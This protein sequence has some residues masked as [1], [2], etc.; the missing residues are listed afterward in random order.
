MDFISVKL[1]SA[2]DNT[3][4]SFDYGLGNAIVENPLVDAA[5]GLDAHADHNHISVSVLRNN[6]KPSVSSNISPYP[7][8]LDGSA[9]GAGVSAQHQK[10]PSRYTSAATPGLHDELLVEP[11]SLASPVVGAFEGHAGRPG[12]R[13][14]P[15]SLHHTWVV[16]NVYHYAFHND[17]ISNRLYQKRDSPSFFNRSIIANGLMRRCTLPRTLVVWEKSVCNLGP[18]SCVASVRP[19][20][21]CMRV[22]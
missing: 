18:S 9:G 12:R 8:D 4:A 2:S 16:C 10:Y 17:A 7:E 15:G 13:R 21:E 22:Q 19:S 14:R 11:R 6:G 3:S 1:I 5:N 20:A